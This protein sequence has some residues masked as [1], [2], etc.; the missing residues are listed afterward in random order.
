LRVPLRSNQQEGFMR[1]LTL[2]LFAVALLAPG[3]VFAQQQHST[4]TSPTPNNPTRNNP[5]V[6]HQSIPPDANPDV[7]NQHVGTPGGTSSTQSGTAKPAKA[8]RHHKA[9]KTSSS[10]NT[11]TQH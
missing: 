3:P 11:A 6:P 8:R 10:N 9:S 1:Q 2:S 7:V 4:Q 5:D